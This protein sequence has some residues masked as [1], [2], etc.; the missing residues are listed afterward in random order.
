[1]SHIGRNC[2]IGEDVTLGDDAHI[3]DNV[4]LEGSIT[5]GTGTRIDHGCILRGTISIGSNNWI[6]PYCVLGTGPQH[7]DF[8]DSHTPDSGRIEIGDGNTIRESATIHRP[9]QSTAT[10]IGSHCYI[11]AYPHIAHDVLIGDHVI[12]TTRVTLGGHV[13]IHDYANIGQ[14]TQIHPYCRI[15]KYAMVGMGSSITK[16][17]PPFALMNR[18]RFTKV[19]RVGLERSHIPQEDIAGIDAYYRGSRSGP[20][21]WYK[22][23]IE[24]FLKRSVRALYAP[25]FG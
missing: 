22:G 21:T 15:G 10:R 4:I 14:G 20:D 5:I 17:V 3:G 6:Y 2:I 19:N 12:M 24:S 13:H 7:R 8:A 23:E 1:M 11:M 9:T 18:Q 16:D 25:N